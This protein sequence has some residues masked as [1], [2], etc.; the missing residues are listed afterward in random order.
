MKSDVSTLLI[1]VLPNFF[2]TSEDL[3]SFLNNVTKN[4]N[5]KLIASFLPLE[6][7]YSSVYLQMKHTLLPSQEGR[8]SF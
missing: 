6:G 8:L 5:V 7:K 3:K 4:K 2:H 1:K